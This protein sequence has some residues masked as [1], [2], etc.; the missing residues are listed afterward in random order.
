M[1][2]SGEGKTED[3]SLRSY[4]RGAGP[5]CSFTTLRRDRGGNG[6]RL[7]L[8]LKSSR[9]NSLSK[10]LFLHRRILSS[11][12]DTLPGEKGKLIEKDETRNVLK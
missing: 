7:F 1:R 10:I 11:E 9:K 8:L 2:V 12:W 4:L 6:V 3:V 5:E